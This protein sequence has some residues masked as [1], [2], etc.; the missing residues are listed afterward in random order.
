MNITIKNQSRVDNFIN[1]LSTAKSLDVSNWIQDDF[2]E[3]LINEYSNFKVLDKTDN[4][5]IRHIVIGKQIKEEVNQIIDWI[6]TVQQKW[7]SLSTYS[8]EQLLNFSNIDNLIFPLGKDHYLV[9]VNSKNIKRDLM[10]KSYINNYYV[11][12]TFWAIVNQDNEFC[13]VIPNCFKND[14]IGN[15]YFCADTFYFKTFPTEA[16]REFYYFV[17]KNLESPDLDPI[18]S[19]NVFHNKVTGKDLPLSIWE[20]NGILNH[21]LDLDFVTNIKFPKNLTIKGD[22]HI[23]RSGISYLGNGLRVKGSVYA[24]NS[25]LAVIDDSVV[26]EGSLYSEDSLLMSY[27][28]DIRKKIINPKKLQQVITDF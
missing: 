5:E 9:E 11:D 18:L 21:P 7:L 1:R 13:V 15:R 4:S 20:D 28:N 22:L 6:P 26:I 16:I 8:F 27:S 25:Q 12:M 10:K 24:Q 14:Y 17:N 3:Y 2:R 19:N 23:Q